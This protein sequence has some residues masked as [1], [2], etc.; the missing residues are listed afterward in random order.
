MASIPELIMIV[1]VILNLK[2]NL[3]MNLSSRLGTA[4]NVGDLDSPSSRNEIVIG[5]LALLQL[6][7]GAVS[8]V[9]ANVAFLLGHF[10]PAQ[11]AQQE[12]PFPELDPANNGTAP[13]NATALLARRAVTLLTER[14]GH[15]PH[16][17]LPGVPKFGA[18][19]SVAPGP[20]TPPAAHAAP[21]AD[22]LSSPQPRCSPR[23]CRARSSAR[24]CPRS[25]WPAASSV[26][27][28]VS[29]CP[30]LPAHLA[31]VARR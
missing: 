14:A 31:D 9:A 24:S 30:L 6:Q 22:T 12:D 19:E 18:L 3:E 2:G 25:S 26:S 4:A 5:N 21:S 8:F 7:A 17:P 27:T 28:P 10:V 1:P 29:V 13:A 16:L 15:I 11:P 20:R 23:A